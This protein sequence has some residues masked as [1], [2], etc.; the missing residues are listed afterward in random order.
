MPFRFIDGVTMA[1][2]AFEASGKTLEE[3]FASAGAALT[4][5]MIKDPSAL[6]QAEKREL[7][8]EA[9]DEE[10]LLHDFLEELIFIK[11]TEQLL[12]CGYALKIAK[13]GKGL[14]L[15]G[16]LGGERLDP[17]KHDLLVDAKAVSRHMFKVRREKGVW[18]AF[19]IVDV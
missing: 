8:L 13:G 15:T 17:K 9:K 19:A 11:D 2:V 4:S 3:M 7:R 5:T 16:S 10:G 1:D 12:F 18:K 6:K 14:V